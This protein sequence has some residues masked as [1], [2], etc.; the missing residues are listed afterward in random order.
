MCD[1]NDNGRTPSCIEALLD[2]P[3]A[4]DH[5]FCEPCSI[6]IRKMFAENDRK[7]DSKQ[8]EVENRDVL[9][10]RLRLDVERLK[11][12]LKNTFLQCKSFRKTLEEIIKVEPEDDGKK[13]TYGKAFVK[14]TE[15]AEKALDT[16][17]LIFGGMCSTFKAKARTHSP[18][19]QY[20]KKTKSEPRRP[21]CGACGAFLIEMRCVQCN[22]VGEGGE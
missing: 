11:N 10:S 19:C 7:L 1:R 22:G 9:I 20:A 8:R 15:I 17:S 6:G 4:E 5:G 18:T 2:G 16:C 13:I 3:G 14:A 21:R 12:K